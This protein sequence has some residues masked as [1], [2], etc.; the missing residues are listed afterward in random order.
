MA[1]NAKK[2]V[3]K[4]FVNLVIATDEDFIGKEDTTFEEYCI[5]CGTNGVPCDLD[6]DEFFAFF[7]GK[8]RQEFR[9]VDFQEVFTD[10]LK[11]K[12]LD[13]ANE[14]HNGLLFECIPSDVTGNREW[15]KTISDY[16]I[17]NFPTT[18]IGQQAI[19]FAKVFGI[20]S[21][22]FQ[23]IYGTSLFDHVKSLVRKGNQQ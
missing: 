21:L 6:N 20:S 2:H 1:F 7:F 18:P 13:P 11:Y 9:N 17:V 8:C 5:M 10:F 19:R 4:K 14:L 3:L 16:C 23:E 15:Y 22:S 12:L